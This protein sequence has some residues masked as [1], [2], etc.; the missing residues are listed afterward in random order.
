MTRFALHFIAFLFVAGCDCDS[1]KVNLA[2]SSLTSVKDERPVFHIQPNSE[3]MLELGR[4]SGWYGL[5][6][7][8]IDQKGNVLLHSITK[9]GIQ[10]TSFVIS[11][12]ELENILNLVDSNNLMTLDREY[13]DERIADGTQWIFRASQNGRIKS[14]YFNNRFPTEINDFA[15]DLDSVLNIGNRN[16][17]WKT[18][19]RDDVSKRLWTTIKH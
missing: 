13:H 8:S 18:V 12:P 7:V 4:G 3:F 6:T 14:T 17:N 19:V 15:R 10:Q 1:R 16:L 9:S 2:S 5:N 11:D